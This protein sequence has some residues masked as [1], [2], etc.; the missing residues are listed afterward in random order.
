MLPIIIIIIDAILG[1]PTHNKSL[2]DI[3]SSLYSMFFQMASF[4]R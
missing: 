2:L 1:M 3:I 4:N